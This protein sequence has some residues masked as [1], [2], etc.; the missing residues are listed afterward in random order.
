MKNC[1]IR[2]I[3]AGLIIIGLAVPCAVSVA[4]E[5]SGQNNFNL[6]AGIESMTGEITTGIGGMFGY[7]DGSTELFHFP[8]SE[9]EWP[10]DVTLGRIDASANIASSWRVNGLF[11]TDMDDPGDNLIYKDFVT[12]ANP[13]RLD[14]YSES[15]ISDF[16]ALI[17]DVDVEWLFLQRET[18]SVYA[19]LGYR[20]QKFEYDGNPIYQYSPSGLPGLEFDGDGSVGI[21]YELT[22][23][24]PYAM[25]GMEIIFNDRFA[26]SG[27]FSYAPWVDGDDKTTYVYSNSTDRGDMDGDAYM[28]DVAASYQITS[29]WYLATGVQYTKI[30]MD[31]TMRFGDNG[32]VASA[33]EKVESSQTSIYLKA[34]MTF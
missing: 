28:L 5:A 32:P 6:S 30:D 11:K 34:G 17:L 26:L 22:N 3:F 23:S 33:D 15:E 16:D 9:L 29:S 14:V 20:Y 24:M 10:L 25:I 7:A 31:G 2:N 1:R 12:P 27:S 18:W 8:V 19:G 21:M 13:G 4:D